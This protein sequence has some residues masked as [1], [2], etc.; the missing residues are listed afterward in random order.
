MSTLPDWALPALG[1]WNHEAGV[2][3][4]FK[5]ANNNIA[6]GGVRAFGSDIDVVQWVFSYGGNMQNAWGG[7]SLLAQLSYG[8]GDWTAGDTT[9]RYQQARSGSRAEYW[10]ARFGLERSALGGCSTPCKARS[11]LHAPAG[12][13]LIPLAFRHMLHHPLISFLMATETINSFGEWQWSQFR[14]RSLQ[15]TG[16]FQRVTR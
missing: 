3:F 2:G 5:R 16:E 14:Q 13:A 10:Y 8:L 9:A 7:T 11:G 4:D 15:P 6:F 12:G 1:P